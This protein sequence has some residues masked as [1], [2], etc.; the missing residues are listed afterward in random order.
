MFSPEK[1]FRAAK[2]RKGVGFV[3]R[4]S[5][6]VIVYISPRRL[7]PVLVEGVNF[8]LQNP[9]VVSAESDR[10]E[11]LLLRFV[12][13][14]S[15]ICDISRS[16]R[17]FQNLPKMTDV[18]ITII[19]GESMRQNQDQSTRRRVGN[20]PERWN[21]VLVDICNPRDIKRNKPN[22]RAWYVLQ[23]LAHLLRELVMASPCETVKD[24]LTAPWMYNLNL[25]NLPQ[26]V[27]SIKPV[28]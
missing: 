9:Q 27:W 22:G 21:Q 17:L 18:F 16:L 23:V 7:P 4:A 5:R 12:S 20:I 14:S 8:C 3:C 15:S 1:P 24:S 10:V 2:S 6:A 11:L 25:P 28:P 19:P 26:E 13:H